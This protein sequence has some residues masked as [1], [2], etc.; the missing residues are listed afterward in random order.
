MPRILHISDLHVGQTDSDWLWPRTENMLFNDLETVFRKSGAWDVVVFSGDLVQ[1]GEAEEYARLTRILEKLWNHFEI[2]GFNPYL[3]VVPGNHDLVRPDSVDPCYLALNNWESNQELR[4]AVWDGSSENYN[5]FLQTAFS[6]YKNWFKSIESTKIKLAPTV[7]GLMPGDISTRINLDGES[8]GL[9]GLNSAWL[10]LSGENYMGRLDIHPRQLMSVTDGNPEKW[11]ASNNWNILVTHHPTSWLSEDSSAHWKSEIFVDD[12]FDCHMFGHMHEPNTTSVSEGGGAM[13][14]SIQAAS[15]FGLEKLGN[16]LERIHGYSVIEFQKNDSHSRFRIW[17]RR[18]EKKYSGAIKLGADQKFELIDDSYME[19]KYGH[20]LT[21]PSMPEVFQ[22]KEM[23]LPTEVISLHS[24]SRSTQHSTPFIE[25]WRL[26]INHAISSISSKGWVW[27]SA[28][29]DFGAENF[30]RSVQECTNCNK[31]QILV[32]DLNGCKTKEEILLAASQQAGGAFENLL[33]AIERS[34]PTVLLL[35]DVAVCGEISDA[36]T[37]QSILQLQK[38]I[39]DFCKNITLIIKSDVAPFGYPDVIKLEAFDEAD[40]RQYVLAHPQGGRDFDTPAAMAKLFLH[41]DGIP[42][43][44]D[45]SIE[46]ARIFGMPALDAANADISGKLA[47]ANQVHPEWVIRRVTDLS[48][49]GGREANRSYKLLKALAVFPRGEQYA[50]IKRFDEN[51]PFHTAD[52]KML[53]NSGLIDAV[54]LPSI[55]SKSSIEEGSALVVKRQVRDYIYAK[56]SA[57][58]IKRLHRRAQSLYF[59][60]SWATQGI[61]S[62]R[63]IKFSDKHCS[64]TR[65]TNANLLVRRAVSDALASGEKNT[66]KIAFDLASAYCQAIR[67]GDHYEGI[68]ALLSVIVPAAD[69][70]R[71]TTTIVE[72]KLA[73]ARALRMCGSHEQALENL[74]AIDSFEKSKSQKQD[75]LLQ[76]SLA[77]QSLERKTEA[78]IAANQC[79]AID[80]STASGAHAKSIIINNEST[81]FNKNKELAKLENLARKRK[82]T[83]LANNIVYDLSKSNNGGEDAMQ[84]LSSDAARD[85]DYYN[86]VRAL[87]SFLKIKQS[88]N[89]VFT[90]HERSRLIDA[91]HY[92]YGENMSKLFDE[93]HSLLWTAFE[94]NDDLGNL[95]SLFRQSSLVWRV[96]DRLAV[97]QKYINLLAK[98]STQFRNKDL[99]GA[100]KNTAYFLTRSLSATIMLIK[101]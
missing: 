73:F 33:V 46:T 40:A 42:A 71:Y 34:E 25:A 27:V 101:S 79:L 7:H 78:I 92:L 74:A 88:K 21:E 91:Y 72:L 9:V 10:Q 4:A 99:R 84:K 89:V 82:W 43:R 60:D 12:R 29:V 86:S 58:E 53:L 36:V 95:T 3:F 62:M 87:I 48:S 96:R 68:S 15:L 98:K 50:V 38:L 17:P 97:E 16:S 8:I 31:N 18:T 67:L 26:N 65:I 44:L 57:Q 52:I 6:N 49:T 14:R 85:G 35:D 54:A 56:L 47:V 80:S 76:K 20:Q 83:V 51:H 22:P 100:D 5:L 63:E 30:I 69:E 13:R 39:A 45:S 75:C 93:C 66:I 81:N 55:N 2:L 41:S 1:K 64:T 37:L 77:L 70:A 23:T 94:Q 61:K 28:G 11:T 90:S 19:E 59:G 24:I 32:L